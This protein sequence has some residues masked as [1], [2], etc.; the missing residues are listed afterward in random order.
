MLV[1]RGRRKPQDSL[2]RIVSV[3]VMLKQSFAKRVEDIQSPGIEIVKGVLL[4]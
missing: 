3:G 1:V 4:S 2:P